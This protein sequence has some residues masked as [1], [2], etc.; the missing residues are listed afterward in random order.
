MVNPRGIKKDRER[1][2][3]ERKRD[4]DERRQ[5]RKEERKN[6]TPSEEGVDPDLVGIVPGPQ[7]RPVDEEGEDQEKTEKAGD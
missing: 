7:P 4:K 6:R 2:L 1:T 3:Q 5:Q